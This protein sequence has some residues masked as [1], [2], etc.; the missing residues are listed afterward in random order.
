MGLLEGFPCNIARTPRPPA[1]GWSQVQK[2]TTLLDF[3]MCSYNTMLPSPSPITPTRLC[4]VS[5]Q[6]IEPW[7]PPVVG[8]G[9]SSPLFLSSQ[10]LLPLVISHYHRQEQ[11]GCWVHLAAFPGHPS[12]GAAAFPWCHWIPTGHQETGLLYCPHQLQSR[13]LASHLELPLPVS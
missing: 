8:L 6:S 2:Y 3:Q 5:V 7:W 11:L 9:P 4:F 12:L 13:H 1:T 10:S